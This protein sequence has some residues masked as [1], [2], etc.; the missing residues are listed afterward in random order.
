MARDPRV[1]AE[2]QKEVDAVN[3]KL[4]R[5]EQIKRFSI[6][7]HD[8]SQAEGELT[9]TLKVKRRRCTPSTPTCSRASTRKELGHERSPLQR[10]R[11]LAAHG[12]SDQ[13]DGH[14]LGAAVR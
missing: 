5:I 14:Q 6:L 4:A 8:F 2:I 9:P 1:H 10:R 12:P 3:E 11:S 7:D 13:S